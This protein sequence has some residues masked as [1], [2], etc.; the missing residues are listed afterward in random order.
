MIGVFMIYVQLLADAQ[1]EL[2]TAQDNCAEVLKILD[3]RSTD[4][5]I[6]LNV[7]MNVLKQSLK[8]SVSSFQLVVVACSCCQ[9]ILLMF[10]FTA[11]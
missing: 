2:Q 10:V 11:C 8:C 3:E 1:S 5:W 7:F 4:V 9:V 6:C